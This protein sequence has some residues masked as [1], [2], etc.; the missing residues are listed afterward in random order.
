MNG[1]YPNTRAWNDAQAQ[2]E[3]ALARGFWAARGVELPATIRLFVADDLDAPGERF[4]IARGG[5]E[6]II[7][8][9]PYLARVRDYHERRDDQIMD[10]E[11]EAIAMTHEVGHVAQRLKFSRDHLPYAMHTSG[12]IMSP[13]GGSGTPR[14]IRIWARHVVALRATRA[15]YHGH[16]NRRAKYGRIPR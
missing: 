3:L 6:A 10:L 2:D 8:A 7:F 4:V 5:S 16:R 13:Y 14:I 9:A 15:R 12:G 1:R 11:D